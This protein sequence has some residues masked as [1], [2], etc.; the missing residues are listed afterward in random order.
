MAVF[1]SISPSLTISTAIRTADGPG[2]LAGPGLEH[3]EGAVLHRELDVLHLLVVRL[4]LLADGHELLVDLGHLLLEPADRLGGADAGDDVLALGV[5]QVVAVED[6][7]A[8]VRVAGEG[9]AGA[10]VVPHVAEDHRLDVDGGPL[11]AG[12][13][14]DPAVLDRLV[15]L[16][17]Y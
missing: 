15:A 9:D 12:D 17:S 2:P 11:Q 3:V 5:D 7:L 8:G 1:S 6:V 4:E 14:L 10:R 13:P 16:P